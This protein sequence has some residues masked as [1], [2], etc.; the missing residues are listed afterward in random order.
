MESRVAWDKSNAYFYVKTAKKI[1]PWSDT[2]WMMLYIDADKDKNTGWEGYDYVVNM[3]VNSPDETTL[4]RWS[5]GSWETVA[6][7]PYQVAGCEMEI[8]VPLKQL[9]L[10]EKPAFY[11]HWV[12]NIQKLN[13]INEFFINGESAPE[14]RYNY[15]YRGL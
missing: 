5:N 4:K 15:Y 9:D 14:R 8:A 2:N 3:S 6:L 1:T 11:F 12:D 13:D 10:T 7:C